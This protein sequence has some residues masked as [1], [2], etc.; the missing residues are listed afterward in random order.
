MEIFK[1]PSFNR[2]RQSFCETVVGLGHKSGE[3][4][5]PATTGNLFQKGFRIY[6]LQHLRENGTMS[7]LRFRIYDESY[8]PNNFSGCFILLNW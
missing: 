3:S 5:S 8:F 7:F 1:C 2:P 6:R 4:M